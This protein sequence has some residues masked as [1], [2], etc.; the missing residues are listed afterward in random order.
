MGKFTKQQVYI[1]T[2]GEVGWGESTNSNFYTLSDTIEQIKAIN[3]QIEML[4]QSLTENDTAD[5]E[6]KA[7]IN[8][9]ILSL[10]NTIDNFN[11]ILSAQISDLKDKVGAIDT[12][13][14]NHALNADRAI[15]AGTADRTVGTLSINGTKFNGSKNTSVT[16]STREDFDNLNNTV[17]SSVQ[18]LSSRITDLESLEFKIEVVDVLPGK[19]RAQTLYFVPKKLGKT[20]NNVY[21]E[22]VWTGSV[23]E[24]VG[25]TEAKLQ[26]F[27]TKDQTDALY[28]SLT[29]DQTI[30]GNKTFT[31][32][33]SAEIHGNSSTANKLKTPIQI[34]GT[35]FDGSKA[36][37]TYSWG[38]PRT[39]R[40][41]DGKNSTS[42][43]T[44]GSEDITLQL[45][46]TIKANVVGNVI[47]D[48]NGSC[49][50][51]TSNQ[52]GF[53]LSD[54]IIKSLSANNDTLVYYGINNISHSITFNNIN[55]A[56]NANKVK[57]QSNANYYLNCNYGNGTFNLNCKSYTDDR[58]LPIT[59]RNSQYAT[60]N[61]NGYNLTNNIVKNLTVSNNTLT[62][63]ELDNTTY[64]LVINN[65]SHAS[66]SDTSTKATNNSNGY[67]LADSIIKRLT[68][69]NNT[70]TVTCIDGSTASLVINNV[71]HSTN[72]D[73]ATN[74]N[75]AT[76]AGSAN[77]ATTATNANYATSAGSVSGLSLNG[78][79]IYVG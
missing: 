74:A 66:S 57:T 5:D 13:E 23:F 62:A 65:V 45:P 8:S 60:N 22:Y 43:I 35:Y 7:I 55:N 10:Q 79:S 71:V 76:S 61:L 29:K 26:N 20:T 31:D 9:K 78:Y 6:Q 67:S 48:I 16:L 2:V 33:V 64:D 19:G 25:D 59:V 18:A 51:A 54:D 32:I 47:G 53:V 52:N 4:K 42:T 28:M 1:P 41:T 72:A 49:D 46:T 38:T 37:T 56:Y 11:R 17:I 12:T 77:S 63:T 27:Y 75:Y 24:L 30:N 44:S 15:T 69:L 21:D 73:N 3:K 34:N 39:I 70:L 50:S 36:I 40:I 14:S 68:V 58:E